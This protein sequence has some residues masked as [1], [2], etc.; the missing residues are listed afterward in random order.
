MPKSTRKER[1]IKS[2]LIDESKGTEKDLH[3]TVVGEDKN[4]LKVETNAKAF[5]STVLT[6]L[7][8]LP[9]VDHRITQRKRACYVKLE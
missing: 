2:K 8:S 9:N 7:Y 4:V 1:D 6:S 3:S 5:S